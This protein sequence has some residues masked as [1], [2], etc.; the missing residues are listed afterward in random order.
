MA[1]LLL[2]LTR[3]A[4]AAVG[5]AARTEGGSFHA[6]VGRCG[7]TAAAAAGGGAVA[8]AIEVVLGAVSAAGMTF[9]MADVPGAAVV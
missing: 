2:T 9:V 1:A 8:A 4:G 6:D 3:A 7:R 5:T